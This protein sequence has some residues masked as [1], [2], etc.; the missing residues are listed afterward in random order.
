MGNVVDIDEDG[1]TCCLNDTEHGQSERR[2]SRTSTTSNPNLQALMNTDSN[3]YAGF[4]T[5]VEVAQVPFPPPPPPSLKLSLG[6]FV[7]L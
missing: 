5:E 2:F 3:L 6:S 1:S 7:T 4:D